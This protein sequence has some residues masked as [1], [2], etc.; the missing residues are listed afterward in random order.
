M[1]T[2]QVIE[3]GKRS[4][5]KSS[6]E[7][8]WYVIFDILFPEYQPRPDSPYLDYECVNKMNMLRRVTSQLVPG[9]VETVIR[10]TPSEDFNRLNEEAFRRAWLERT[11]QDVFQRI[12]DT[13]DALPYSAPSRVSS[14]NSGNHETPSS[15]G[16]YQDLGP[17]R[18]GLVASDEPTASHMSMPNS[19]FDMLPN[20]MEQDDLAGGYTWPS[21]YAPTVSLQDIL[22]AD[23]PD[24]N[25]SDLISFDM[26]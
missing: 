13:A 19:S 9:V 15:S 10:L 12:W 16:S 26:D 24:W 18:N 1:T 25:A 7:E 14:S 11:V 3:L 21:S 20:G 23:D 6:A 2:Q 4:N 8:Q 5:P 17:E 22:A